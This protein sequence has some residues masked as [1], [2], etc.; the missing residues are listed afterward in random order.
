MS[1]LA[2]KMDEVNV[3]YVV[4]IIQSYETFMY[5]INLPHNYVLFQKINKNQN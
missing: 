3:S 4:N 1:K 5:Y 2:S